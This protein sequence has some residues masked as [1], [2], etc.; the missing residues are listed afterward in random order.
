MYRDFD[1]SE[2]KQYD[3]EK[4]LSRLEIDTSEIVRKAKR[5]HDA[6]KDEVRLSRKGKDLVHRLLF[7]MLY[8]NR[9]QAG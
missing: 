1:V 5:M 8:R 3:L 6:G 4:R 2:P 7:M 9:T